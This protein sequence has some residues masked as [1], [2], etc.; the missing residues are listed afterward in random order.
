MKRITLSLSVL[1]A[2]ALAPTALSQERDRAE[3]WKKLLERL[4][5]DA[6]GKIST[7]ELQDAPKFLARLDRNGDG[8][9]EESEFMSA[10][11]RR[12][13][14]AP[15]KPA[16]AAPPAMSAPVELTPETSAFFESKIRPLLDRSCYQ[17]HS[18]H[19]EKLKGG[20]RLD[21]RESVLAGGASGPA[22]APGDV[23]GSLLV[24]AVRYTDDDLQMP[25][26][27]QLSPDE[28]HDLEHWVELGLPWP[29]SAASSAETTASTSALPGQREID[30]DKARAFWAFRPPQHASAPATKDKTW[31]FGEID[32]FLLAGMEQL[33]AK[34]VGD[35]DRA[36]W[37]RRVTL[38]LTGLPP[39]PEELA[40]FD[41][42][43]SEGS[44]AAV[45][46]RLLASPAFGERWGRH[47]LDVARYAESS[48]KDSNI[49]YPQAW[50][51]RDWVIAAFNDDMPYD[52]FLK[53]QLAGDLLPSS[54]EDERAQ[55]TIATGYLALGAKS[56]NT[57]DKRQ[58]A[59]D[60][61]DE[62]IDAVSQG[63]L[64]LTVSC[65]RCHDHKFDPI[66]T[67]DY[68]A[69]AG[70]FLSTDTRYGTL[71]GP[72]NT[73]PSSLIGLPAAAHVPDGPQMDSATRA[74]LERAREVIERQAESG[75]KGDPQTKLKERLAEEQRGIL[76]DLL[77]RFDESGHA[78]PAN[79]QAMGA[80][81][82]RAHD[83]LVL[84][85]GELD[86]AR[87]AV[88]RGFLTVIGDLEAPPIGKESGRLELADWIASPQNPLTARVWANRIWLH[89]FGKGLVRTTD[90]FGASGALPSNQALLDWLATELVGQ[91]WST[92]QLVRE[93][94]LSHAYR[95]AAHDESAGRTADPENLT[96][97]RMPER[98]LEAEAIRDA[99]LA[100]AGTLERTPPVG[101]PV[102]TLE[103][104]TRREELLAPILKDRPVRSVYLPILRDR[105]PGA[106]E[107]FDAAE[108]SF[109]TGDR[110]E[111]NVATQALYLMNDEDV[112]RASDAFAARV[113]ASPGDEDAHIE[114]AFLL[115]LGRKP[116]G[117]ELAAVRR[118][119]HEFKPGA[120]QGKAD[121]KPDPRNDR[122]RRGRR[123]DT[124]EAEPSSAAVDPKTQAWSAFVQTLF[125]CAEF[126]YQS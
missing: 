104:A 121:A 8:L 77:A 114:Q 36:A 88:P 25:P 16:S 26:K 82:G 31:A 34:P 22:A 89:L 19:S 42:D 38:D 44:Y 61:A 7:A 98:R 39:T 116:D 54:S 48:G 50:R 18:E 60:L 73:N 102:G 24:R 93:I 41:K 111:T 53:E 80:L 99:M 28:L 47:W 32:R 4:D 20:L 37:L 86:K 23:E 56:H 33:G 84:E 45:V 14:P 63:M 40:G 105:L 109:V 11:G 9:I 122:G 59:Y 118:F 2:L 68:Y 6:D 126:R 101:S 90:N 81:E 29:A 103:G 15:K 124:A 100:A 95:L 110:D 71:R 1:F 112:L 75:K 57:R 119:L 125:G 106:L 120:P 76:D 52:R 92:K 66:P 94:V 5:K 65:A 87:A 10:P 85:R 64:G 97:W 51:Y 12:G 49:V 27:K 70:I 108:P 74:L 3:A 107:V 79:R 43:R 17:C 115:A 69:L 46:D 13:K 67:T 21:S 35:A 78:L 72:G 96:L 123:R 113:L 55:H 83:A 91:G 117:T 62:Q 58:F 30:W